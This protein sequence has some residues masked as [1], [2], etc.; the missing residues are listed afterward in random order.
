MNIRFIILY[1]FICLLVSIS[2]IAQDQQVVT[3]LSSPKGVYLTLDARFLSAKNIGTTFVVK[4][5][6]PTEESFKTI[7]Q[8]Q[9]VKSYDEFQKTV[10]VQEV[11]EFDTMKG[12]TTPAQTMTYLNSKPTYKDVELLGE[13]KL[14]FKQALGFAFLDNTAQKNELYTYRI[15]EKNDA[16]TETQVGEIGMFY[17]PQNALL[18]EVKPQLAKIIGADSSVT[19]EWKLNFPAF[20]DNTAEQSRV[21]GQLEEV[22]THISDVVSQKADEESYNKVKVIYINNPKVLITNPVDDFN[23]RF[24][25]YYRKNGNVKWNFLEKKLAYTDSLGNKLLSARVAGKLDD[26]VET[27]II[28]EDYVNNLGDTSAIAR[29]VVAHNGTIELIYGVSATD[30]TNAIILNWKKL[31]DKPYYAGIEIAKSWGDETA[32]VIQV[33]PVTASKFV[34]TEVYPAGRMFTYFVR[35]VFIP[36][37]SLEQDVPASAVMTC[38]KFTRPTPPFNLKVVS[39]GKFAKL[40]WEVA[41]EKAI[42]SYIV[43]RGTS[44][45]KMKPIRSAVKTQQYIDSTDYLS[46]RLTYYYSVM[47]MNVTQDTSA[48][49]PYVSYVPVKKEEVQSPP[50]LSYEILNNQA[51]LSWNDVKL[52]DD[53]IQGYILERK[54]KG[55][56]T[57]KTIHQGIIT[58][59]NYIDASFER[60]KEYLY[61]IASVTLRGDT[62]EF[63]PAVTVSAELV[64]NELMNISDI[65][66]I[67]LSKSIQVSWPS[68]ETEEV[69]GYKIYRKLPTEPEFK[70]LAKLPNGNFS[71]EDK[72]VKN[73]IIYVYTVTTL[74]A[75]NQESEVVERKS[76]YREP[77]K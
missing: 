9:L 36:F 68:V 37:Q 16:K 13:L 33:L 11:K 62:A 32:K 46:A 50:L 44:P 58:D 63:S 54:K 39:E 75:E 31:S 40:S 15:T 59:A 69:T 29:G 77:S 66:L 70:L 12:F 24:L 17:Y 3:A 19:F 71:Y 25:I 2:T 64:R 23:T 67:N 56:A 73:G 43:Y 14:A 52:N 28:P 74:N 21:A 47:A 48:Y 60:G 27:M 26:L 20:D 22:F 65:K 61:R 42:F 72:Q 51:V 57:F 53:F 5:K 6:K 30:S 34:D 45:Q 18:K 55:D 4:R 35:P 1:A 41:D 8:M 38:G 7:G 49:A 10:G 76:L